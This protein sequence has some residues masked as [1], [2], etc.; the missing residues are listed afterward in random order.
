M[1]TVFEEGMEVYDEVFF[2]QSKGKVIRVKNL[3]VVVCFECG[4]SKVEAHYTKNGRLVTTHERTKP[5]LSTSRYELNG[6]KQKTRITYKKALDW[7]RDNSKDRVIYA[8]EA[9]VDEKY[10]KAFYA[11]RK[12]L[13]LREYYNKG[14]RPNWVDRD[15]TKFAIVVKDDDVIC[16][17]VTRIHSV[18][19]F[20]TRAAMKQFY[21]EQY[22]LLEIAKP[23]L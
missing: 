2:P 13:V 18:L 12:L 11:L 17:D 8:D 5:T 16:E 23:L 3:I 7:L 19:T 22:K 4:D 20:K 14:W 10:E 6:L 1:E 21:D 9:Y 15:L